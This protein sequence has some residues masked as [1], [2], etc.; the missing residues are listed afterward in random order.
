M[1]MI[2]RADDHGVD[3][4]MKLI[5]HLAEVVIRSGA[6]TAFGGFPQVVLVHVAEGNDVL[7]MPPTVLWL[8]APRPQ[9]GRAH[10]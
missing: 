2:R 8:S 3:L 5:E 9:I 10:V 7:P 1:S 4:A 6:R